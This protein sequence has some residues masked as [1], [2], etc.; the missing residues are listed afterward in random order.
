MCTRYHCRIRQWS[1]S[2]GG[3]SGIPKTQ[4]IGV[5]MMMVP[6]TGGWCSGLHPGTENGHPRVAAGWP[7]GTVSCQCAS[8]RVVALGDK[9][10]EPGALFK[11]PS[12]NGTPMPTKVIPPRAHTSPAP[13][14]KATSGKVSGVR[15]RVPAPTRRRT[16]REVEGKDSIPI[17]PGG[18]R[19]GVRRPGRVRKNHRRRPPTSTVLVAQSC[20]LATKRLV[21]EVLQEPKVSDW[22][23]FAKATVAFDR[24]FLRNEICIQDG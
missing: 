10:A 8:R 9:G 21:P 3:K 14:V 19:A 20:S 13:G 17:R 18:A 24:R 16:H 6:K 1:V 11:T 22:Q 23:V 15:W 4:E 5:P 12:P 7:F 2:A